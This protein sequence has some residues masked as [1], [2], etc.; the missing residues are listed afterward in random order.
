MKKIVLVSNT[1]WALYNFRLSLIRLLIHNGVKVYCIANLDD[2]SKKLVNEGVTF[3][4]SHLQNKGSNP[5]SDIQYHLFLKKQYRKI[6]PDLIFHYTVKPNIY[7]SFAAKLLNIKSVAFISGTGHPFLKKNLINFIVK[8]LYRTAGANCTEMWFINNDD[9]SLF[10]NEGLVKRQKT[11][12]LPGEGINTDFFKR[13]TDYPP[14]TG[15]FIFLLSC[16]ML[17]DKGVGVYVEAARLLKPKYPHVKFQLLGFIDESD[18]TSVKR[19]NI[20]DWQSEGIVEYLGV[21][22]N[23]IQY[24][25]QI[26]CFVLPSFYKEGIPKTLLE[27][28]SLEIPIITTNNTGCRDVVEHGFNGLLCEPNQVSS[29]V[30]CM[31]TILATSNNELRK[32]GENGRSKIVREFNEKLVLNQYRNFLSNYINFNET[33]I[34]VAEKSMIS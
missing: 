34:L 5:I 28:S 4:R 1:S 20:E 24:L 22:D 32:M 10:I 33:T 8:K 14:D 25:L 26:N 6:N 11:R 16:R 9:L 13:C 18:P 29:L 7:G 17:W 15:N 27:A 30:D 3:I 12:L 19:K 2:S 21:T 23:V 31:E